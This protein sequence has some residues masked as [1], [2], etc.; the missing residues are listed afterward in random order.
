MRKLKEQ[1]NNG[2]LIKLVDISGN[3]RF[4]GTYPLTKNMSVRD[5]VLLAGGLKE[6][7]YL[8]NAEI[9]RRDFGDDETATINHLNVKL[10]NELM[11]NSTFK[12]NPKDKLAIY[13]TPEYRERLAIQLEG[14]VRFPGLYEFSRGE[15]LS[16]VIS[17]AGGFT[18]MAHIDASVFTRRDLKIQESKRLQELKNR[19]REDIAASE[20]E[21][22]EAGKGGGIQDAER[23]LNALAETEALGRLVISL[24]E[25]V[26][27]RVNDI[28]LK[29]GDR[30]VVPSFRQEISVVGEVQ[31]AT[32][33]VFNEEWTL[34]DYLEKS[35]GYTQRADDDR[36][37]VVRADGSVF[38]PNQSNWLSHQNEMLNPG[39]TI[40]V[41]LDTDRIKSLSL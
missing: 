1:T 33:H 19:M 7:S 32:S 36:I 38:L 15:T 34:E 27:G 21:N 28:Q 3:I 18:S 11:G 26:T 30:L 37:Y 22:A 17:R 40:V 5:L 8:G 39:D 29:D 10:G 23:L 24:E 13:A 14:E 2:G 25:I 12:L 35:G 20:L 41:P 16:Q 31:H 4:P 6:A 9:T